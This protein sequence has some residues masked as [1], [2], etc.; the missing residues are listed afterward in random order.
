MSRLPNAWHLTRTAPKVPL[1]PAAVDPAEALV[2]VDEPT[3]PKVEL[4]NFNTA[5]KSALIELPGI[6]P[7]SAD[8]IIDS[9]PHAD[10]DGM[11]AAASLTR[12][13]ADD[14]AAIA[15]LTTF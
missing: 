12:L 14:I 6:G 10:M 3:Q 13:S 7:A 5:T 11:I 4:V 2:E 9:R 1:V 15:K 8:A